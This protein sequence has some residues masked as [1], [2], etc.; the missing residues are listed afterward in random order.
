LGDIS[1]TVIAKVRSGEYR[2]DDVYLALRVLL[3]AGFSVLPIASLLPVKG[4]IQLVN[5]GLAK[6]MG[7]RLIEVLV[8]ALDQRMKLVLTG[9]A[10][11]QLGDKSKEQ[12]QLALARFTGKDSYQAGDITKAVME[13]VGAGTDGDYYEKKKDYRGSEKKTG[14]D[15]DGVGTAKGHD[16]LLN[17]Q[18]SVVDDLASWDQKFFDDLRK[19]DSGEASMLDSGYTLELAEWDREFMGRPKATKDDCKQQEKH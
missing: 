19:N 5:L 3:T 15:G 6:D 12:L 7:G 18:G 9:D 1:K 4:L 13:R 16:D 10:N 17:L 2:I 11:Y 14:R 8:V